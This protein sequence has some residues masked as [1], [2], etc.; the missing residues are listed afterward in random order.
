M[1]SLTKME[2]RCLRTYLHY[3]TKRCFCKIFK[4]M[5]L[6]VFVIHAYYSDA[7]LKNL[8]VDIFRIWRHTIFRRCSICLEWKWKN[9]LFQGKNF[10]TAGSSKC[11]MYQ[12]T[13][14]W[15]I[16]ILTKNLLKRLIAQGWV[17]SRVVV[18][19]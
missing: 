3:V 19:S 5:G 15:R 12:S 17:L 2:T 6:C 4:N 7:N 11:K 1:K 18:K 13:K 9:L 8:W 16:G 10:L 14:L